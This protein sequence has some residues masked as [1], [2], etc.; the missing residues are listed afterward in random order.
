ME[1]LDRAT[2]GYLLWQVSLRFRAGV[3]RVLADLGVTHAQYSL[4]ASLYAMSRS[5]STPSQRQLADHTGLDPIFVSKLTRALEAGGLITRPTSRHDSRAVEL[6]L[7]SDGAAVA[8]EA[9]GRVQG[10]HAELL[11][12]IGGVDGERNRVLA[13]T[14]RDILRESRVHDRTKGTTP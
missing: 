9:I 4:L 13:E 14:L 7:T 8:R 5:G 1:M 6:S 3:D 12:P 11:A 10:L 2:T